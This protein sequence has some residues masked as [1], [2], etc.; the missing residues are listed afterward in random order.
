MINFN[1]F[2]IELIEN[3]SCDN[4]NDL[5]CKKKEVIDEM[6]NKIKIIKNK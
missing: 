2:N 5:I 6:I 3:F 1:N 4:A